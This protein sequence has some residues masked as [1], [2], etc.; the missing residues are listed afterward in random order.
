[1]IDLNELE[2]RI[3]AHKVIPER[4]AQYS[5]FPDRLLTSLKVYL[6]EESGVTKL[7]SHQAEMFDKVL[8]GNDIVITTSTASGKTLS[9]LLPV[10]QEILKNPM[11]RAIFIYPTKSLANDQYRNIKPLLDYFGKNIIQA[12]VYDGDTPVNERS[13][14]RNS[15][16]IILT[17]PEMINSS[18]LPHH[19]N[20]GFNFI[21]SNLKYV[22]IDEL[23]TYR[24]AFGS[25]LSNLMKRLSRVS[26]YYNSAPQFLCSSATIANPIELAENICSK[27]FKLIDEDGSPA[28]E[29]QYYIWQPPIIKGTDYRVTPEQE[30]SNLL[31]KMIMQESSFI[32]FCKSRK[33]VEVVLKEARDKLKYDGIDGQDFTS[34]IS[35]YRG[36]YKPQERKEIENKM[37]NGNLKGLVSTNA[38]EL[39]IDIGRVD[40]TVLIGFPG[41]RASFWQQSGRAGRNGVS[42]STVLI[43]DNR[44]FD[45][46][47]AIDS[48]WLFSNGSEN[49]VVDRNNLFIQLAHVR[50]ATA[51]IPLSLDDISIFPQLGEI[52]PVLLKAG[53]LR[54]ENGKFIWIGPS[55]PAGDYSL[56]NMDKER[57]KLVNRINASVLTE[58]D[59]LQAFREV[60][61]G[62]I[63][64]HD[65]LL[66]QVENL[67]I[68]NRIAEAIPI[69]ANYYTVPNNLTLVTKIKDFK[70]NVIGRTKKY[71]G[72]VKVSE[73]VCGYKRI[74]FHNHQ[75]LG[76]EE[77]SPHLSKSFETEGVRIQVPKN[78]DDV[79]RKLIPNK[80]NDTQIQFWKTYFGG[81]S[82][83]LLNATMMLT[84]ATNEDIGISLLVEES[85]D[86]RSTSI[87]I[88]DRYIGG[89]GYSEKAYENILE[90]INN[91]IK[92][93]SGC[94]CKDGCPACIG[95]YNLDKSIVLWGLNNFFEELAP[96]KDMKVPEIAPQVFIEK[97]FNFLDLHIEWPKLT[98]FIK[99][100]GEYLSEFLST[101]HSV[102]IENSKLLL[103]LSN[104]FYK[105]WITESDN[106]MKLK[107]TIQHYVNTP[108]DFEVDFEIS[109]EE[110]SN[111][112]EKISR[113]YSDLTR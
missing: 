39:G 48:E 7:Y 55:F 1:M 97:K 113:R 32:A 68:E 74:Q 110:S 70:E 98:N 44:P 106:K 104:Q 53:E 81:L 45:Q 8:D 13:R 2:N 57:Y 85:N 62:A 54:S 34:L 90:I 42:S 22:V 23:H 17:N 38:L 51:E 37:V 11:T 61:K 35:G 69:N 50:A 60:H 4:S 65:G 19:N 64:L 10:V 14:I 87:C 76:Y 101:I 12:G 59:E 31:P 6:E 112:S 88:Y 28:P 15:A 20:Y 94:K 30:A 67:N 80:T 96:L 33:T 41:T 26:K 3:I 25:H 78:V 107:N 103:M 47:I 82:Y 29:K 105:D 89:L 92:M 56:R 93:V 83:C 66:Y 86:E 9:F 58:M 91:S 79:Y 5:N 77:L 49:A 108:Q 73:S 102:R 16:N 36:G 109:S 63:Y 84:M 100:T 40:S 111:I 18:F 99:E 21:F 24:G 43:L 75:N 46:Y 95:D 71:F 72:D 27:D 52:V